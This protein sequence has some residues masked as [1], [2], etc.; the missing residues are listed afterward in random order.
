MRTE[1]GIEV[2]MAA[3]AELL[4]RADVITVGFT[5]FPERILVDTR[6]NDRQGQCA[7]TVEPVATVQERYLW[8]GANR[9]SFGAPEAFSFFVWP[10]TVRSLLEREAL[11]PLR[12]R[13]E[14]ETR[15]KFDEA[16]G[17]ALQREQHEMVAAVRGSERWPALWERGGKRADR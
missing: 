16:L 5:L 17:Q 13:L 6:S 8:L 7:V 15:A 14:P 3:L 11:A 12:A 1:N 10:H 2:D 4:Q 9:G